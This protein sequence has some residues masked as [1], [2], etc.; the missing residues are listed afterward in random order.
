MAEDLVRTEGK[1]HNRLTR[2]C[3]EMTDAL[4][5]SSENPH[6]NVKA[7]V[8]LDDDIERLSGL[9]MHGYEDDFEAMSRLLY[10]IQAVFE[11]NQQIFMVVVDGER[12]L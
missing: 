12:V 2:I 7:I 9:E 6:K 3:A 1:P 8:F 10:H 11:A 4:D 5:A